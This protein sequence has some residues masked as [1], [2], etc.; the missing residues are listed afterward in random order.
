L[1]QGVPRGTDLVA[2]RARICA[3]DGVADVHDL[4]IWSVAGDDVSLTAHVVIGAGA[5]HEKVRLAVTTALDANYGIQHVTLQTEEN[6][7][8][9]H[10]GVHA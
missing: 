7:C 1:M 8:D 3:V 4:H 9:E 6:A 10:S 2:I 5:S